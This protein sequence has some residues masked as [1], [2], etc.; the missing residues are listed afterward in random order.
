MVG[1]PVLGPIGV[2]QGGPVTGVDVGPGGPGDP[3]LD[4]GI[5]TW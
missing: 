4:L 5:W 2:G 3:D 1:L